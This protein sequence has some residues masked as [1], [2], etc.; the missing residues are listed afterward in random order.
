M[1]FLHSKRLQIKLLQNMGVFFHRF[2]ALRSTSTWK[3]LVSLFLPAAQR[4][5]TSL[6]NLRV[7]A[8]KRMVRLVNGSVSLFLNMIWML[9]TASIC[10]TVSPVHDSY[11]Y[12]P[13]ILRSITALEA[14]SEILESQ[15]EVVEQVKVEVSPLQKVKDGSALTESIKE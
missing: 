5:V 10:I 9:W 15:F 6:G 1:T 3:S 14:A 2:F 11:G 12:C 13:H 4:L 7:R 8:L